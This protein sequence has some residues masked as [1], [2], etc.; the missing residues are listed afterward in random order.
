[1]MGACQAAY[2]YA[3][4][5]L[6]TPDFDPTCCGVVPMPAGSSCGGGNSDDDTDDDYTPVAGRG[7]SSLSVALA[8]SCA[9]QSVECN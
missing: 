4:D 9:I 6:S 7:V 8:S 2:D 5:L 1:M 3:P